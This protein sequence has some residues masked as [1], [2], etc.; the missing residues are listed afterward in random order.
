MLSFRRHLALINLM[1]GIQ[2]CLKWKW[3]AEKSDYSFL[4][5]YRR[6]LDEGLTLYL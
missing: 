2:E 4:E 3:E 1:W 6:E 5:E